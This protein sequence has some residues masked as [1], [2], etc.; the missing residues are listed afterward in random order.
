MFS[1]SK[2]SFWAEISHFSVIS[3]ME[4]VLTIKWKSEEIKEG[5][6]LIF[7][8]IHVFYMRIR[9]LLALCFQEN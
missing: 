3:F 4:T 9:K 8:A 5:R 2:D 1:F 7:L 6:W